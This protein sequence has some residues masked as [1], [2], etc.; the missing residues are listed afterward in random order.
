MAAAAS[1]SASLFHCVLASK[2]GRGSAARHHPLFQNQD[3]NSTCN[4][5]LQRLAGPLLLSKS[6]FGLRKGWLKPCRLQYGSW[7]LFLSPESTR[8]TKVSEREDASSMDAVKSLD[9][10]ATLFEDVENT[11]KHTSSPVEELLPSLDAVVVEA[12]ELVAETVEAAVQTVSSVGEIE[13]TNPVEELA[14]ATAVKTVVFWV[15]AAITFGLFIWVKDGT[16]KASEFFAGYLV[17]Q[18]L[19]VD[20]LFVFVVIFKYFH[21]PSQYQSRILTYGITGAIVFRATVILLGVA[22]IQRFEA[23]NLFFASILIF[24]SYKLFTEEEDEDEDLSNNYIVNTCRKFIPVTAQYDENKFFTRIEGALKATPL[25]LTL[26]V[27]ELSDIAF[28]VDSIPAVFGVTRDPFIVFSS[29]IFAI[30][31]LRS[32]YTLISSSMDELDYLQPSVSVVLGFIGS[33]MIADFLG[34]HIS[35]ETSLGVVF[36]VLGLGVGLSLWK[37][38]VDEE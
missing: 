35:T 29:N 37:K 2:R 10:S 19:S 1:C 21:V 18:S 31:G 38:K 36:S 32:L 7:K 15:C 3:W 9:E 26:A 17:E 27:I 30:L 20:N 5:S 14:I 12:T 16:G 34:F 28:A 13:G 6:H 23:V 25:F 11:N 22:T 33:K 8:E 4:S 24:T